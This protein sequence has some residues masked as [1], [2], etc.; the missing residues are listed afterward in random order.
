MSAVTLGVRAGGNF[1]YIPRDMLSE[2]IP[3]QLYELHI[4]TEPCTG[5]KEA[6]ADTLLI[7]LPARFHGLEIRWIEVEDTM[8]RVQLKGSPFSWPALLAALPE[9]LALAGVVMLLAGVYML[10]SYIPGWTIGLIIVGILLLWQGPKI[11]KGFS[12]L[13]TI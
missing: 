13:R 7:E 12:P 4:Q 6:V 2:S 9:I 1:R 11:A 10:W 3:G 5:C 8:I